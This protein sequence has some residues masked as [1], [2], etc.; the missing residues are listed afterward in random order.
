MVLVTG[1]TGSGKTTTLYSALH[2]VAEPRLNICTLEDP[3]EMVHEAFNQMAIQPKIGFTFAHALRTVLR[4]DPDVI[5]VGE[6]R[7]PETAENAIQAA[8][9]GHLVISTIHTTDTASAITRLLD[10]GVYPF[11][12]SSVLLGVIAQRLVRKICPNCSQEHMLDDD[13]VLALKI[14]GARGRKLKVARGGGCVDCRGTGYNGRTGLFEVMP[15]TPRI[16]KLIH[17]RAPASE[18]KRE[19]LNDG[20]LTLRECAIK[21]IAMG[22]TTVE[23]VLAVT[24]E[25]MVY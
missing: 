15:V 22:H 8:L 14:R 20:M 23:E 24:D 19:A 9:T 1:P 2:H 13:Q 11:L 21:K 16:S 6:I 17:D 12:I 25:Q 10:L 7:D 3:I 5:M 18:I 4:Q